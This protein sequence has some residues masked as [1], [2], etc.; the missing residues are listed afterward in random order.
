[1]PVLQLTP[2]SIRTN[3][4]GFTNPNNALSRTA[5]GSVA[6]L[7]STSAVDTELKMWIYFTGATSLPANAV[8]N[9][10]TFGVAASVSGGGRRFGR[11]SLFLSVGPPPF[12]SYTSA[13]NNLTGTMQSYTITASS[14]QLAADGFTT[15][16]LRDEGISSELIFVSTSGSS[17]TIRWDASWIDIDYTLP[18]G[19]NVLFFGENF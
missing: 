19:N 1:M 5:D 9:S 4:S 18:A 12:G 3:N 15:A 2:S 14:S 8:I 11:A 16:N 7:T 6:T 10:I 17:G 13:S